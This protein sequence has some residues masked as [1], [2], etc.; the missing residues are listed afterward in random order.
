[1][2]SEETSPKPSAVPTNHLVLEGEKLPCYV[3][4]AVYQAGQAAG[5]GIRATDP[6]LMLVLLQDEERAQQIRE[7]L[8]QQVNEELTRQG[9][10]YGIQ[11]EEVQAAIEAF[12]QSVAT[13]T[14][15]MVTKKIAEGQLPESGKDGWL[16]YPLNPDKLPLQA[17]GR[18]TRIRAGKKTHRV[19]EGDILVER[20]APEGGKSGANVRGESV[21]PSH[22][23]RDIALEPVAGANTTLAGQKVVAAMEGVYREDRRGQVRVVQELRVDE[24]NAGTGDLPRTGAAA[25]SFWVQKGVRRGF[26]IFTTEDVL[27]GN[28]QEAGTLDGGMPVRARNLFVRGQVAGDQLPEA[29]LKGEMDGLEEGEQTRIKSQLEKSQIEV[30]ELFGAREVLSRNVSAGT[31]LVQTHCYRSGLEAEEDVRV[32]G[33]LSGGVVAFGGRLQVRGD[34][35]NAEGT[36]TRIRLGTE[37]R[38]AQKKER[39]KAEIQAEKAKL[40]AHTEKLEA[41]Q[42]RMEQRG[43]KD[44]YWAQLLKG[45]LRPP[46]GPFESRILAQFFQAAKTK[47]RLEREVE[48]GKH[49]IRDLERL[50]Q[51]LEEGKSEEESDLQVVVGGTFYPGGTVEFVRLLEAGDLERPVNR[52]TGKGSPLPLKEIKQELA[53]RVSDYLTPRQ[54]AVEERKQALDQMFKGQENRPQAP[55]IPNKQFRIAL[56]FPEE[57][58]KESSED[59]EGWTLAMDGALFVY[60]RDPQTFYLKQRGTLKEPRKNVVLSVEKSESG[61]VFRCAPNKVH[62]TSWQ[63]DAEVVEQ[64]ESVQVM[65]QSAKK[66][67]LE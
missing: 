45:E 12:V 2:S 6:S 31:I 67:L 56:T 13:G 58:D 51:E 33:N 26:G 1:M 3:K 36:T 62:L 40:A 34:L 8:R 57:E 28:V 42:E 16:E 22:A 4:V 11:E 17:L 37:H 24:V 64:L 63:Q 43:K 29:Y 46:R 48:D 14:G 7:R 66:L 59:T 18:E 25:A 50:F 9:I 53:K 21:E 5:L 55:T 15:A 61:F 19:K 65:G 47:K 52:R 38:I 30:D 41:Y 23:P 10:T 27:V 49:E 54:E 35:G 32:D 60:A 39:F 44:A 20:H